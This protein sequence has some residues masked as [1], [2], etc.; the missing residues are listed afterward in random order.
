MGI[1][2]GGVACIGGLERGPPFPLPYYKSMKM[3]P[4]IVTWIREWERFCLPLGTRM[5]SAWPSV[6]EVPSSIPGATTSLCW[7]LCFLCCLTTVSDKHS[8]DASTER[9]FF[10]SFLPVSSPSQCC[11]SY[12]THQFLCTNIGGPGDSK[13]SQQFWLRLYL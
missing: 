1:G 6:R 13:V 9:C 2:K 7:L 3:R 12:L 11:L 8:W 4:G 5:I 10:F